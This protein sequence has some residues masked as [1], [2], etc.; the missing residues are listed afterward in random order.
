M[1]GYA[2]PELYCPRISLKTYSKVKTQVTKTLRDIFAQL[3]VPAEMPEKVR[4]LPK[5]FIHM[6]PSTVG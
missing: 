6:A 5:L 2:F 4:K 3:V 1:G